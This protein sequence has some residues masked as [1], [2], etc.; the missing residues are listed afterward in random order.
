ML[1]EKA[2]ARYFL[3]DI[4]STVDCRTLLSR[5]QVRLSFLK[6]LQPDDK[7]YASYAAAEPRLCIPLAAP[8][9]VEKPAPEINSIASMRQLLTEVN[10]LARQIDNGLDYYGNP[11]NYAPMLSYKSYQSL[12]TL[13]LA[14][15]NDAEVAYAAYAAADATQEQRRAALR[16][17]MDQCE[18]QVKNCGDTIELLKGDIRSTAVAVAALDGPM[19][20]ARKD[21]HDRIEKD[22]DII[23]KSFNLFH[24]PFGDIVDSFAMVMFCPK[25]PMAL[26]QGAKIL[27]EAG[28]KLPDG[29]G[30]LVEKSYLVNQISQIEATADALDEGLKARDDGPDVQIDDPSASKLIAARDDM[31][32]LLKQYSGVL[33]ENN[34]EDTA[35]AFDDYISKSAQPR[36]SLPGFT[37]S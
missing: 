29:T 3:D 11:A 30:R 12:T 31:L 15:A 5:L 14:A 35:K 2:K 22:K 24:M 6:Y 34:L 7:L 27:W 16:S 19:K 9:A 26:A 4:Q 23:A 10:A 28:T 36:V 13:L 32:S 17:M 33:G 21:M 37:H 18:L 8:T 20:D 25:A 1:L